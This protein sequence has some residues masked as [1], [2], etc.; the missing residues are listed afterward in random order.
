MPVLMAKSAGKGQSPFSYSGI[1]WRAQ[2]IYKVNRFGFNGLEA[3]PERT[4]TLTTA[5]L[6]DIT[7]LF[8]GTCICY[9]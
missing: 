1:R 4:C 9:G 2:L 5:V 3:S 7:L 8:I 6:F